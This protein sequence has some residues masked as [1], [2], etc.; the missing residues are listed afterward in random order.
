MTEGAVAGLADRG[1]AV[2]GGVMVSP[3]S[4]PPPHP[5]IRSVS[6]DHP[7]PGAGSVRAA[8]AI[9]DTVARI[10][11]ADEVV[12]LISGGASSL[13]AAP[14]ADAPDVTPDDMTTLYTTLLASGIDIRAMNA[15]RRRF[16]R[17]GGGRLA[18]A[19]AS[20]GGPGGVGGAARA[21]SH[22][23]GRSW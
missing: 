17:W 19:L 5:A 18:T 21:L 8:N 9:G 12:V 6:G 14:A 2:T 20:V 3:T 1:A 15:V 7:V 13:V 10:R 16:A 11:P 4:A 23:L 22:C